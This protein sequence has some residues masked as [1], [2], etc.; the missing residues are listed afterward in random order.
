M[1]NIIEIIETVKKGK[2]EDLRDLVY[3]FEI[4]K[5]MVLNIVYKY[6]TP[7]FINMYRDR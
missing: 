4:N 3:Q 6:G 5:N 2:L 7:K 1:D